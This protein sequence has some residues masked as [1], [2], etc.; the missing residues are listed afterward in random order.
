[1]N[2]AVFKW[3]VPG[4]DEMPAAVDP[5]ETNEVRIL[6]VT[7]N[8]GGKKPRDEHISSL[9]QTENVYHDIYIVGTQEALGSIVG[10]MFKP[11]KELMIRMIQ[12][13]LGESFVMIGSVCLQATHLVI[14]ASNRISPLISE[15]ETSHVATGFKGKVG[16]KGAVKINFNLVDQKIIVINAHMHSGMESV[17]KRNHDF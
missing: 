11:S 5:F 1:M 2:L 15:V 17:A 6:A 8:L 7:W 12:E 9:L 16:N 3:A 14:F 4:D 10:S 13:C